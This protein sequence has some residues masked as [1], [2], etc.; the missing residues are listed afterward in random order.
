MIFK[1][2]DNMSLSIRELKLMANT[3]RR[4]IVEISYE[5]QGPSHPGPALSCTDIITALYFRFM[6]IDPSEPLW[7]DRDRLILSKGHACPAV[8]SALAEKGF[9]PKEWLTTIRRIDSR[10]QGHPDMNKTPGIDMT[11]GSLGNGLS[12]GLGMALYQKS[13]KKD[14][15][16]YVVL[17]DGE[18]QEGPVW[19][20]AMSAPALG[21]NNLITIVDRNHFQSCGAV[22]DIIPLDNMK[23]MWESFGWHVIEMNGHNMEDIVCKLEIASRYRSKPTCIIA[24]TIKGKG[25]SFMENNNQWHQKKPTLDEYKQALSEL[26]EERECL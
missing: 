15:K 18:T 26:K 7:E 8:Y 1:E 6:N 12:I 25:V 3:I 4:D 13:K 19:E 16:V 14:S 17:G 9:F 5:A 23:N 22:E 11:S 20:A 10:L 24:H 21:A 2:G